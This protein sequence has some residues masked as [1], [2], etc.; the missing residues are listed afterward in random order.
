VTRGSSR[1]IDLRRSLNEV[2]VSL[3]K[4][5]MMVIDDLRSLAV[6]LVVREAFERRLSFERRLCRMVSFS[7][8]GSTTAFWWSITSG[9]C[10]RSNG[11]Y[12]EGSF[13]ASDFAGNG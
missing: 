4:S 13:P 6:E 1:L 7:S 2:R 3:I 10:L 8:G 5:L 12:S 9:D 11:A